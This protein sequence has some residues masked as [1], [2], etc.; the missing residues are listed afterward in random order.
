M[1]KEKK[2]VK[3]DDRHVDAFKLDPWVGPDVIA[4]CQVSRA[5]LFVLWPCVAL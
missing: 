4:N 3:V 2:Q 5:I 1:S